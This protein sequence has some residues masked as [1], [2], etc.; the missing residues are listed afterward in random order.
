M[1]DW[2]ILEGVLD[3][4]DCVSESGFGM[5]AV[6]G[7]S[8]VVVVDGVAVV[9]FVVVVVVVEIVVVSVVVVRLVSLSTHS[10]LITSLATQ[11]YV[12]WRRRSGWKRRTG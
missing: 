6:C 4:S 10:G 12:T 1:S 3:M 5:A 11:E 2:V 8:V 9:V 7:A